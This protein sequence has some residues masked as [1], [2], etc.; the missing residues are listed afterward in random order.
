MTNLDEP[1]K[2]PAQHN[3][4]PLRPDGAEE[5]F[6]AL[7]KQHSLRVQRFV[8]RRTEHSAVEDLTAETFATAW[9]KREDIPQG[10]EI[11]WLYKTAGFLVANHNRKKS[12]VLLEHFPEIVHDADPA[13][14]VVEDITLRRAFASLSEKDRKVIVLAAWEGQNADEIAVTLEL[15][16]NAAAVALSRARARFSKAY[17]EEID[18]SSAQVTVSND[19]PRP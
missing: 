17:A 13:L 10:M 16:T 12:A 3:V 15:S 18:G 1:V 8:Y 19:K 11:Q 2:V 6:A 7:F 5:W 9:R 4:I 14:V